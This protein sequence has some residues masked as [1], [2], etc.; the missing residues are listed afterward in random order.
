MS[1]LELCNIDNNNKC[2]DCD[3]PLV[4]ENNTNQKCK[5]YCFECFNQKK[6]ELMIYAY[7]HLPIF[8]NVKDGVLRMKPVRVS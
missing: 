1:E 4:L 5:G 8:F 6:I 7:G 2:N 3:V